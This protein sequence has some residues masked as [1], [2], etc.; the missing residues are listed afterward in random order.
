MLAQYLAI[1]VV[2]HRRDI[3]QR[4]GDAGNFAG[5]RIVAVRGRAELRRHRRDPAIRVIGKRRV[6][7]H[8]RL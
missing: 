6:A 7:A 8:R 5:G 3:G 1:R 4:V 2:A